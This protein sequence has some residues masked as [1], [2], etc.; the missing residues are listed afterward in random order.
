M[1][2]VK[3][4]KNQLMN[5]SNYKGTIAKL[6]LIVAIVLCNTTTLY[7]ATTYPTIDAN[8]SILVDSETGMIM[9]GSDINE[10]NGIASLTKLMSVYVVLDEM[11]TQ[12]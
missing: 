4:L 7:A 5:K 10:V 3:Q 11:K 9:T 2:H 8:A 6:F 1:F 12:S